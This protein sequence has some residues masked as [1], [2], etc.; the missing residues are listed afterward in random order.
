[1]NAVDNLPDQTPSALL[2]SVMAVISIFN[3][4]SLSN[5]RLQVFVIHW[6]IPK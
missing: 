2:R 5:Q 4:I 1:M 6:H 3:Y